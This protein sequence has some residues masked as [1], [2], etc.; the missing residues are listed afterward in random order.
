MLGE[1]WNGTINT[2]NQTTTDRTS[3]GSEYRTPPTQT[4][5]S[6]WRQRRRGRSRAPVLRI[7]GRFSQ[8][9]RGEGRGAGPDS[10]AEPRGWKEAGRGDGRGADWPGGGAGGGFSRAGLTAAVGKLDF[11]RERRARGGRLADRYRWGAAVGRRLQLAVGSGAGGGDGAG[12]NAERS[13]RRVWAVDA[14]GGRRAP[15]PPALSPRSSRRGTRRPRAG[16]GRLLASGAALPVS[17][18]LASL[19]APGV[20]WEAGGR[21]LSERGPAGVERGRQGAAAAPR[22]RVRRGGCGP[23]LAEPP[24]PCGGRSEAV[25]A[26]SEIGFESPSRRRRC[27]R[28]PCRVLGVRPTASGRLGLAVLPSRPRL[29]GGE[30]DRVSS[31]DVSSSPLVELPPSEGCT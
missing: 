23:G 26:L 4:C 20:G 1:S 27:L 12:G 16:P 5:N 9:Q 13:R 19:S 25:N 21:G 2:G 14:A 15:D 8:W 24:G 10:G 29:R 11:V 30:G 7:D 28:P 17:S 3:P 31:P 6:R 22:K 18:L